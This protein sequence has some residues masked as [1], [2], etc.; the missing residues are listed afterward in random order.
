MLRR[1]IPAPSP[2]SPHYS[3]KTC[4]EERRRRKESEEAEKNKRRVL[5]APPRCVDADKIAAVRAGVAESSAG[6]T[7]HVLRTLGEAPSTFRSLK[8]FP[9]RLRVPASTLSPEEKT[10]GRRWRQEGREE[11]LCSLRG[12]QLAA[13]GV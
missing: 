9:P 7:P 1:Q 10:Q 11:F 12:V 3:C 5:G 13:A 2:S 8:N 4:R 6:P